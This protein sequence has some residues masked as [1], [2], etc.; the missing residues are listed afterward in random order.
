MK[1]R[2]ILKANREITNGY[3]AFPAKLMVRYPGDGRN[4]KYKPHKDFSEIEID[5]K[6]LRY[7]H[8]D[9]NIEQIED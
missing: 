9:V 5:I 6:K 1:A 7:Q 8:D 3:V 4:A 2:K